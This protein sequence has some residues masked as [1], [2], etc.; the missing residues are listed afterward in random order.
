M[1]RKKKKRF[2]GPLLWSLCGKRVER[3]KAEAEEAGKNHCDNP[4]RT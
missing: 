1:N 4:V 3:T 2:K